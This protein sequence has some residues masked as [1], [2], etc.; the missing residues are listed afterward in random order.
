MTGCSYASAECGNCYARDFAR[1]LHGWGQAKYL[2][3]FKPTFHADCLE[4]PLHWR[5]PRRIFVNSMSDTFHATD[6]RRSGARSLC[7]QEE[8]P[9]RCA[10]RT[11]ATARTRFCC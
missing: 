11:T 4:E 3:E 7:P 1:R 5:K 9:S 6:T 8:N 2:A 10:L